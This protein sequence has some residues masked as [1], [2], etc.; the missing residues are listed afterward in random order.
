MAFFVVVFIRD[1]LHAERNGLSVG[2][3]HGRRIDLE[4]PFR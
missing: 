3:F 4:G 1:R 2:I